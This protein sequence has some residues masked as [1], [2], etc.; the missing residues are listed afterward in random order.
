[1]FPRNSTIKLRSQ[2]LQFE[3]SFTF[4][5]LC[6]IPSVFFFEK[7][8]S[9]CPVHLPP[10]C[11]PNTMSTPFDA[12]TALAL[13]QLLNPEAYN[14]ILE[15]QILPGQFSTELGIPI[16]IRHRIIYLVELAP[17]VDDATSHRRGSLLGG[18]PTPSPSIS[19]STPTSSSSAP[20]ESTAHGFTFKEALATVPHF[21]GAVEEDVVSWLQEIMTLVGDAGMAAKVARSKLSGKPKEWLASLKSPIP[22]TAACWEILSMSL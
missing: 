6:A 7:H 4:Q 19:G 18:T 11:H 17:S 15:N 22:A 8:P 10:I 3:P 14:R 12:E 16:G 20:Q 21:S 5:S 1:M 13:S 2:I 9:H